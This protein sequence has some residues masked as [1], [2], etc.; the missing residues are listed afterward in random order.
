MMAQFFRIETEIFLHY[1][2]FNILVLLIKALLA[3]QSCK[4]PQW[5]K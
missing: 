5:L 2:I 4:I 1:I 3:G